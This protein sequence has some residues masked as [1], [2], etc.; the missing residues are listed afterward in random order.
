VPQS[1]QL[2]RSEIDIS[3]WK[4]KFPWNATSNFGFLIL[5]VQQIN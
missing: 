2:T 5:G 3:H 4:I 1:I